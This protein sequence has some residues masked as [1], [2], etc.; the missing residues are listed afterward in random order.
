ML[1]TRRTDPFGHPDWAFEPKWDG[2]R[3]IGYWEDGELMI[4]SRTGRDVTA[5]YPELGGVGFD[6]PTIFDGEI[7]A[8]DDAGRPSFGRLQNRMNV[9]RPNLATI[10]ADPAHLMVFDLLYHGEPLIGL[11]WTGRRDRLEELD[12]GP[13]L[14]VDPVMGDGEGMWAAV[15]EQRMEGMVA[16]RLDSVYLPGQ[17]SPDWVKVALTSRVKAVVG[18]FVRG[19][20]SRA[21]TFGSLLLGLVDGDRL[22]YIG[23]V[24]TGFDNASLRAIKGA[25][26]EMTTA[27]SPFHPDREMPAAIGGFV[28]PEL[29]ALVEFKEW[30]R[31]NKLRAPSFKGFTDDPW[32]SVT[33]ESEGPGA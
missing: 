31:T 13:A 28:V 18:G 14:R 15:E 21:A 27:E 19:E 2:V 8:L 9:R 16:K 12:L 4:R 11:P 29:T 32:D 3:A 5:T 33:W 24:G 6:R 1:A 30:T 26:D 10:E 22:R 20:R 23:S 7:I 17:R 25:L